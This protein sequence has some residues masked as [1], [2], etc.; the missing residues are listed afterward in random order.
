[1]KITVTSAHIDQAI[2]NDS[3]HCMVADALHTALPDARFVLVDLQTIRFS[4]PGERRRYTF[5]TPRLV[6]Q[7]L[8]RFDQGQP[9]KPFTFTLPA[10]FTSRTMGWAGQRGDGASR[11]GKA[12]TYRKTGKRRQVMAYRERKFGLRNMTG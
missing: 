6:Q 11:A 12:T 4:R 9:V 1:M 3:R 7:N 10:V 2:A 5:L 8:L